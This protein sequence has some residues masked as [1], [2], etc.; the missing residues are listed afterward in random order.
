MAQMTFEPLDACFGARVHGVK[1]AEIDDRTFQELYERWIDCGLLIFPGQFLTREQQVA[2]AR[3]FGDLEFEYAEIG[4][5]RKDG[6]L[7]PDDGTDDMMKIN[8]GNMGWH[9]DSTYMPVQAKGAV[10]SA[11]VCPQEGGATGFADMRAAWDALDAATREKIA[12]LRAHHS[13]YHS[14]AKVGHK[15]TAE[16]EMKVTADDDSGKTYGGYGFHEGPVS[17]RPLVKTHPETGAK[18]LLVGRHAYDIIGMDPAESEALLQELV[19]FACQG[20]RTYHHQWEPGDALVWDNRRLM[21]RAT[22]WPFDQARRMWHSRI[23]GDPAT[24]AALPA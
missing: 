11:E 21:H 18:N 17:I 8:R 5:M 9:H 6:T 13:L 19:D 22:M 3:R 23:A 1:V 15:A 14:Q 2:F 4:N 12:D 20:E 10:F 7:R 16:K 24:E